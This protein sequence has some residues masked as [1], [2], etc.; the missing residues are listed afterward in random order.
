MPGRAAAIRWLLSRPIRVVAKA[1]LP[2]GRGFL[3]R[4]VLRVAWRIVEP[5]SAI[6]AA[7]PGNGAVAF[8]ADTM[9]GRALWTVGSFELSELQATFRLA[10]PGT[11]A[12]DVGAN[13]GLF[14]VVMSRAVGEAGRVV[15]LEPV[16]D[17]AHELRHN[18]DRNHCTNVD[19]IEAAAA[20]TSGEISLQITDDPAL[21]SAGGQLIPGHRVI[22]VIKTTS[23]TLDDLWIAAGRPAVSLVKVDV[24]GAERQ[25]LLGAVQMMSACRP[26]LIVEVNDTRE[27]ARVMELLPGHRLK[28]IRGFEPWNHLFMPE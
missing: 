21:H 12:F 8:R 20:A 11:Y 15:A 22:R 1:R 23:H 13:V 19:V 4:M 2:R 28:R 18:L 25:V 3:S 9:L 6:V 14:T 7:T 17:N 16:V 10:R 5:G 24:E 27:V 26:S